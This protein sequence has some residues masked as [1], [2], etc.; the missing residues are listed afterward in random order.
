MSCK[1]DI[2]HNALIQKENNQV[3]VA[4]ELLYDY[5]RMLQGNLETY[6]DVF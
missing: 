1:S 3:K 2:L 5:R 6:M 4:Y